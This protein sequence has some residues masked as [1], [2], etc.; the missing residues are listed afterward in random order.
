MLDSKHTQG[1]VFH[2]IY[3]Y[4]L[5]LFSSGDSLLCLKKHLIK[6]IF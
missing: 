6:L 1:S 2:T 5:K 4:A 3:D